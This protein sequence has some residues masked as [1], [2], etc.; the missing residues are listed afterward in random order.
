MFH[1]CSKKP[2]NVFVKSKMETAV[3]SKIS[4]AS[5]TN[6]RKQKWFTDDS[7]CLELIAH[8]FLI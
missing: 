7:F 6:R 3:A 4:H 5:E 8:N 2:A 1:I